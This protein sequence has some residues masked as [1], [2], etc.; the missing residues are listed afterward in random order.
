MK[1]TKFLGVLAAVL[2][3]GS[4]LS[5]SAAAA[6]PPEFTPPF[7]NPFTSTSKAMTLHTVGGFTVKCKADTDKGEVTGPAT[8]LLRITFTGCTSGAAHCQGPNGLPGEIKTEQLLGTL[9]YVTRQPKVV[10][11]DLSSPTGG[12]MI[13]FFCGEDVR[14][15]VSGSLIGRLTPINKTLAPGEL[16]HLTFAQKEGH[17]TIRM[18]LGGPLDV[19]MTS[20]LGGP[21]Q[22]TG[23]ASG[24][25]LK[26]AAAI[27]V[28]A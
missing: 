27:R 10:G 21:L 24:D 28:I 3:A 20:V 14:A 1:H 23:L 13:F 26:F 16:M 12:P 7:P 17:Q 4:A 6:A 5:V 9:G 19:P 25:L 8:A 11:L 22:E 2:I 15:E 18:L